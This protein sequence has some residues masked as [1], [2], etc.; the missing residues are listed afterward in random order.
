MSKSNIKHVGLYKGKI[1]ELLIQKKILIE[2]AK[3][4][5]TSL[6]NKNN[7]FIKNVTTM[8][9]LA[10]KMLTSPPTIAFDQQSFLSTISHN[11]DHAKCLL[12]P[13]KIHRDLSN[14]KSLIESKLTQRH[15]CTSVSRK[16]IDSNQ[17]CS[18]PFQE[19]VNKVPKFC[20]KNSLQEA[21]IPLQL[22]C[23]LEKGIGKITE[24]TKVIIIF[25]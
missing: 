9:G 14:S 4:N 20:R 5:I 25:F 15:T 10:E 7:L 19:K 12:S 23:F 24:I 16:D 18:S 2:K 22:L 21:K 17:L 11:E 1:E 8:L 13:T 6:K 3:S